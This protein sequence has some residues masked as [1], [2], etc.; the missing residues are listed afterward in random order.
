MVHRNVRTIAKIAGILVTLTVTLQAFPGVV[1]QSQQD[2]WTQP[3][4]KFFLHLAQ[5]C[6]REVSLIRWID[7]FDWKNDLDGCG[8]YVQ[9]PENSWTDVF[10]LFVPLHANI[11]SGTTAS[12]HIFILSRAVDQTSVE[13]SFDTGY[14]KCAGSNG[15][16]LIVQEKVG[17]FHEFIIDCTFEVT[18]ATNPVS[19]ANLTITVTAT[20]TYGYGTEGS[21]A[22]YLELLNVEPAPPQENVEL[23]E[24]GARP[25]IS[26]DENVTGGRVVLEELPT[27]PAKSP[28]LGILATLALVCGV[29]GLKSMRRRA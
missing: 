29:L 16:A 8:G 14:A 22:S 27:G 12:M 17:G 1:A 10:P 5:Y 11:T 24:Q 23:F 6:D 25:R 20:H 4:R 19:E 3:N 2:L 13:A 21:H 18:G 9:E 26:F 7:E 15:P 28:G